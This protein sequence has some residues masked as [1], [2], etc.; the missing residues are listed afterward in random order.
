ME[1]QIPSYLKGQF[2]IAMPLLA[3]PN[4]SHTV[5]FICEHTHLG[6]VGIGVNRIDPVICAKDIFDGLKLDY[7]PETGAKPIHIGGPVHGGEIFVLHGA[8]FHWKNGYM[9]TPDIAICS[10]MEILEAIALGKGPKSYLITL[11]CAGWGPGQLES[12][13]KENVWLISAA[14]EE[15]IFEVPIEER[16]ETTVKKM[17]IDPAILSNT[18][19]HA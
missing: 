15:I 13:I 10:T 12:E 1:K 3:D 18:A 4:F 6:A 9:I 16:W 11:G 14:D 17:G 19:G 7:T 2:L 5:T 8:P